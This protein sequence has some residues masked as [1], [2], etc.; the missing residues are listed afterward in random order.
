MCSRSVI[1][2]SPRAMVVDLIRMTCGGSHAF[3]HDRR[4]RESDSK[5]LRRAARAPVT[6]VP[7]H[8]FTDFMARLDCVAPFR[9]LITAAETDTGQQTSDRATMATWRMWK[10]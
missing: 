7:E 10:Q 4:A 9:S 8:S 1:W 2:L 6:R 5:Y 3:A